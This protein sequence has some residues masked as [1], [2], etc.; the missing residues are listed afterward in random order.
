MAAKQ[1]TSVRIAILVFPFAPPSIFTLARKMALV[2]GPVSTHTTVV[3]GGMPSDFSWPCGVQ[4][5]DI[6]VRLH[7]L[8][9]T[10]PRWLSTMLWIAKFV[11]AQILLA[12]HVYELRHETDI[13]ICSVGCYYQLPILMARV[14]GMKLVCAA[15]GLDSLSARVSYGDVMATVMS[16]LMRFNFAL[17]HVVLVESLRLGTYSDVAPFRSKLYNG[18]LFLEDLDRFSVRSTVE[19]RERLVGYIGRLQTEK[20]VMEF[21]HAIPLALEQRPDLRFL[22]VGAGTLDEAI[23]ET[24]QGKP[25]A[26]RLTWLKWVDHDQV[27][28]YLNQL[29]L[30]VIPS[31]SEGLPN[32]A[33]EAMGCGT[34]VLASCVGGIPD[35][36][37]DGETGFM[38]R[39][40]SPRAIAEAMVRAMD[41]TRLG[42]ITQQAR[43]RVEQEYSF[44]A[45]TRRYQ[46]IIRAIS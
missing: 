6:G 44:G 15:L 32:L 34:P 40:N 29:K 26:S 27:P 22:I 17:S 2:V 20:G 35:L 1:G 18:A 11:W 36:V 37:T 8:K 9:E 28:G 46:A 3:S 19:E 31:Y 43:A 14:L 7:Y 23:M 30:I 25:W 5:R 13:V 4:I 10:Q 45:A 33:L 42:I 16:L 41:D 38:L 12:R 39:D 24:V 21:L